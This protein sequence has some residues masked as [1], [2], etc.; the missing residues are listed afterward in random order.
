MDRKIKTL[1][2][3]FKAYASLHK[4]VKSS[5]VQTQLSVNEFTVMEALYTKK[6]LS[7]QE[8]IDSIL[9]PNSS[10][11]YVLDELSKRGY[12]NRKKDENDRRRQYL[13]LTNE[14]ETVFLEAYD[15]HY[16]HMQQIFDVLTQEEQQQLQEYLKR[17]GLS[18]QEKLDE[19]Y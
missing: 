3:L 2:V 16:H 10:L 4:N 8:L 15:V 14:G 11:T 18:A 5:L 13:S 19:T 7:T 9:I 12:L 1:I 17:I 6:E